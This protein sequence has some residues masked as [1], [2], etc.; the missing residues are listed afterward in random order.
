MRE[1]LVLQNG[2]LRTPQGLRFGYTWITKV[3]VELGHEH[4]GGGVVDH[5]QCGEG[6]ACARLDRDASKSERCPVVPDRRL[7]GARRDQLD[8]CCAEPARRDEALEAVEAQPP[9]VGEQKCVLGIAG[10]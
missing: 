6:T 3:A 4:R 5:P 7:A 2:E 1:P 9:V 10:E 8:L